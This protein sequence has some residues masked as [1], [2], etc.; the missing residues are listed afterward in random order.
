MVRSRRQ[1]FTLVELLTVVLIIAILMDTALPAYMAAT[2]D[3]Q[4]K[5]CRTN[6]VTIANAVQ[7][8][9]VRTTPW[10]NDYGNIISGGVTTT[11]LPDLVAL[12]VC[13]NGGAYSL[14][15]GSSGTNSTF[16][17]S[18]SAGHGTYQPGKD[19]S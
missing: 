4:K 8:V 16:H 5:T 18:C 12:P 19:S 7:A 2:S 17:V 1:G 15:Q 11:N 3:S 14:G 10:P 13:P 6:M 9:R